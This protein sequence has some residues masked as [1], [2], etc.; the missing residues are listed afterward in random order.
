MQHNHMISPEINSHNIYHIKHNAKCTSTNS[1]M[2]NNVLL[3][4]CDF[5][6]KK[7]WLVL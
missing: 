3:L 5:E 7:L 6:S 1:I 4:N 2:Y